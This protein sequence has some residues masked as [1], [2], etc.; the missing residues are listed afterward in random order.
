MLKTTCPRDSRLLESRFIVLLT[1]G[2]LNG[3]SLLSDVLTAGH[4]VH[5]FPRR[6]F[7][8]RDSKMRKHFV[9][10]IPDIPM[11]QTPINNFLSGLF[12]MALIS[13]TRP[14]PMDG[15][16]FSGVSRLVMSQFSCPQELRFPD[17][18]YPDSP[19]IPDTCL[20]KQTAQIMPGFSYENSRSSTL[21]NPDFVRSSDTHPK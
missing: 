16:D 18:G 8:V 17:A 11:T 20:P 4:T 19:R 7:M 13:S 12:P 15:P 9:T 1:A 2:S 21:V 6:G 14:P 10:R 5:L 3:A